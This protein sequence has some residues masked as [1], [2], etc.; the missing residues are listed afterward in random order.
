MQVDDNARFILRILM[1]MVSFFLM[2][3]LIDRY[4]G[5]DTMTGIIALSMALGSIVVIFLFIFYRKHLVETPG[6]NSGGL[7]VGTNGL[8]DNQN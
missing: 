2:L 3:D 8:Y 6:T 4:Q 5:I 7:S 1:F